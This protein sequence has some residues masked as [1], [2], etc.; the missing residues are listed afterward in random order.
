MEHVDEFCFH[1]QEKG[2]KH[3]KMNVREADV[4]AVWEPQ[5]SVVGVQESGADGHFSSANLLVT[6]GN[7][8]A[9]GTETTSTTLRWGLLFMAKYPNIQGERSAS[10]EEGVFDSPSKP[11]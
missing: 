1:V 8:F 4:H 6:V 3:E 5:T 10:A 9:A 11:G 7:L 2:K